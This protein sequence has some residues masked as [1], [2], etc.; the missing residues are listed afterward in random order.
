MNY[1]YENFSDKK[2]LCVWNN[3]KLIMEGSF[4]YT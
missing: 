3:A 2:S 4:C 1:E